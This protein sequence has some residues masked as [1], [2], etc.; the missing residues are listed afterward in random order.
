MCTSVVW[1]SVSHTG[2]MPV[3]ST[4]TEPCTQ[5]TMFP[6][7]LSA[8]RTT[9]IYALAHFC[10]RQ[11]CNSRA[12]RALRPKQDRVQR[13]CKDRP[14]HWQPEPAAHNTAKGLLSYPAPSAKSTPFIFI[15]MV[16]KR[17]C[18]AC[19]TRLALF[20]RA[21]ARRWRMR[22]GRRSAPTRR[23]HAVAVTPRGWTLPCAPP[24]SG[25]PPPRHKSGRRRRRW[26]RSLPS[27][28]RCGRGGWV[29]GE[30]WD[31]LY[32]GVPH[33]AHVCCGARTAV[34]QHKRRLDV[35]NTL[36]VK[37][38][39]LCFGTEHVLPGRCRACP[40]AAR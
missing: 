9:V 34:P 15:L 26:R 27:S 7:S 10:L 23:L 24:A 12:T 5:H 37:L 11:W 18:G 35:G 19:H 28:A 40:D 32:G 22:T 8:C 25:P 6:S 1:S 30:G 38:A 4:C 20:P 13:G 39:L 36:L 17:R 14:I 33:A 2:L 16:A 3:G 21:A 31:R 29:G